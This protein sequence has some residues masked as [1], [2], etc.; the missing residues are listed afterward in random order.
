MMDIKERLEPISQIYYKNMQGDTYKI[1]VFYSIAQPTCDNFNE[2]K[3]RMQ[4]V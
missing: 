1:N 2:Q 3:S 4:K